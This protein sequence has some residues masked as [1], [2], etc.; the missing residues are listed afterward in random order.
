MNQQRENLNMLK[1]RLRAAAF[2]VALAAPLAGWAQNTIQAI[3]SSQQAG[4]E[5]VRIELAEPLSALPNGFTV[6]A[7]PRVALDLP[8]IGNGLG[9]STIDINQGNLRSVSVAQAGDRTRLVFNLKQAANYKAELQG[10]VLVVVLE[11]SGA[12]RHGDRNQPDRRARAFR[13]QSEPRA[14][15]AEGH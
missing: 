9:R 2:V 12:S 6:Q 4:S 5:V 7:P 1:W 10:K 15:A 3:T 13:R 8:G 11:G 14:T